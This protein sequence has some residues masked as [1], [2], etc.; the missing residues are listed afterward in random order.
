M[1]I[2]IYICLKK[3]THTQSKAKETKEEKRKTKETK[4]EKETGNVAVV[5]SICGKLKGIR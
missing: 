4:E 1:Y 5:N 3:Q 2:R